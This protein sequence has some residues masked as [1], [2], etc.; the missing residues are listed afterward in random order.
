MMQS[1]ASAAKLRGG[2]PIL[3]L[4]TKAMGLSRDPATSN[5]RSRIKCQGVEFCAGKYL[6]RSLNAERGALVNQG[7]LSSGGATSVAVGLRGDQVCNFR[8][9]M[10]TRRKIMPL[11]RA[12]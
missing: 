11:S 7:K 9:Q 12:G 10:T 2:G 6:T 5:R 4:G 1:C 3:S 8:R